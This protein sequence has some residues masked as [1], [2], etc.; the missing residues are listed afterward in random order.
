M[1]SGTVLTGT[2]GLTTRIKDW[3]MTP[4]TGAH[5][6]FFG[7]WSIWNT[8]ANRLESQSP[9]FD[10]KSLSRALAP[11]RSSVSKPSPNHLYTGVSR[12]R[13]FFRLRWA[14]QSRAMLIAA[15]NSKDF[16]F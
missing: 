13:A 9:P 6:E 8:D 12:S 4:A 5:S 14:R 11:L 7:C 10:H 2:D 16:A 15:R 1:N 3:R